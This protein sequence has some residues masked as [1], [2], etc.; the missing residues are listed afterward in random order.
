M[1]KDDK[2]RRYKL[3]YLPESA[4]TNC[5]CLN[6]VSPGDTLVKLSLDVPDGT[7]IVHRSYS[8]S[9]MAEEL[10]L[11]NKE[12]PVIPLGEIPP[13]VEPKATYIQVKGDQARY[14][15]TKQPLSRAVQC[16]T[17]RFEAV[18]IPG[19]SGAGIRYTFDRPIEVKNGETLTLKF[20]NQVGR[21]GT[22]EARIEGTPTD[23]TDWDSHR[24]DS[25][26]D[27]VQS[28]FVNR[29]FDPSI[30]KLQRL[31]QQPVDVPL[32]RD[33]SGDGKSWRERKPLL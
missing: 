25:P 6:A 29:D 5:L 13:V 21:T 30:M 20:N 3:A 33:W 24:V 14:A 28:L 4:L 31:N 17:G 2:D 7:E 22:F 27:T 1:L 9:R 26:S 12:W 19:H 16:I 10:L 15:E 23:P 11:Y 8:H 18:D 32:D